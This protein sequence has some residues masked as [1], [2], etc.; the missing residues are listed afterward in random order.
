MNC[1]HYYCDWTDFIPVS[2]DSYCPYVKV[3]LIVLW[4]RMQLIFIPTGTL[5][6]SFSPNVGDLNKLWIKKNYH[7]KM[8]KKKSAWPE[9]V[10]IWIHD[11]VLVCMPC[12]WLYLTWA[13]WDHCTCTMFYTWAYGHEKAI[14]CSYWMIRCRKR[15]SSY[16]DPDYKHSCSL[17]KSYIISCFKLKY[18]T[19][20]F[21]H[22]CRFADKPLRFSLSLSV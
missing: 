21:W 13:K 15:A 10:H 3:W 6:F 4:S 18:N 14:L 17:S 9:C 16:R 19:A 22:Y 11:S 1:C 5:T 8:L 20:W 7:L 2:R 12:M